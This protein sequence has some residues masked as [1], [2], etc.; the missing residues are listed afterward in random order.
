MSVMHSVSFDT[1]RRRAFGWPLAAGG[2]IVLSFFLW[3]LAG[4]RTVDTTIATPIEW[5]RY[6][7]VPAA[8]APEIAPATI[9][10]TGE[11]R[12]RAASDVVGVASRVDDA[13]FFYS[14]LVSSG[15]AA[16]L[17]AGGESG[18]TLFIPTDGSISQLP[19][20]AI[21]SLS[22][23]EQRR[24]VAHHVVPGTIVDVE[25][26][27]AGSMQTLAGEALNF[28]YGEDRLPMVGNAIVVGEYR[29]ANGV[30]YVVENVLF[31]PVQ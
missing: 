22:R 26:L 21:R 3:W 2:A 23:A 4:Q 12:A 6:A 29:A 9:Y 30:V 24:L 16:E 7:A 17:R 20:G 11:T 28:S 1:V 8:E 31:P 27:A 5:G 13:D 10:R 18:Y 25:A 15:V 19:P 14:L